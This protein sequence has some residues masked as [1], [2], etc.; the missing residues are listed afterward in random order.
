MALPLLAADSEVE[1]RNISYLTQLNAEEHCDLYKHAALLGEFGAVT[2]EALCRAL[3]V[4]LV[5]F[6]GPPAK[7]GLSETDLTRLHHEFRV[8]SIWLV[9]LRWS[10]VTGDLTA[11]GYAD[12][13][14]A[15]IESIEGA[16]VGRPELRVWTS[17]L[18]NQAGAGSPQL[19]RQ[20]SPHL[21]AV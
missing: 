10:L 15:T 19:S 5:G 11:S 3:N 17:A 20:S 4:P 1:M 18:K 7:H 8:L 13:L 9:F 12:S 16:A 6:G 2:L 14:R 21:R